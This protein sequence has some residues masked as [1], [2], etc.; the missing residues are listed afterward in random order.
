MTLALHNVTSPYL[1]EPL[2]LKLGP[3]IHGVIGPN[4]TGKT[5][6]LRL[7]AGHHRTTSGTVSAGTR[8]LSRAG[9]DASFAG[10]TV[11]EHLD[12][13]KVGHP[14]LDAELAAEVL[15]IADLS[16]AAAIRGLS[17]GHR[18]LVSVAAALA[19]GAEVTWLDEPFS[20]LDV[21]T[22]GE[23][24]QL[25]IRQAT[26]RSGWT[27][28]ISSHRAEDLAGLA[29]DVV[30]L[31]DGRV[32]GPV[33]LDQVRTHYPTLIGPA[34]AVRAIAINHPVVEQATLGPTLRTT[35]AAALSTSE[36]RRAAA[37]GVAVTHPDDQTLIGLLSTDSFIP[38]PEGP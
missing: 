23:L 34:D 37:E 15:A 9:S 13:A 16:P 20:G 17:L 22:R 3:G 8:A 1:S 19:A 21:R 7:I 27:L 25:L 28:L 4:G 11:R 35:L 18:Q 38:A 36:T 24:R 10:Y 12:V 14:N 2:T 32:H 33:E 30:P 26:R 31:H 6:L 29:T 5:T